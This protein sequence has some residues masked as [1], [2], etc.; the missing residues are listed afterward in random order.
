[1]D[2]LK[3]KITLKNGP[4]FWNFKNLAYGGPIQLEISNSEDLLSIW[5]KSYSISGKKFHFLCD[6]LYIFKIQLILVQKR[7]KNEWKSTEFLQKS[8]IV[9][10]APCTYLIWVKKRK[11]IDKKSGD[12]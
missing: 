12:F 11:E 4:N 5:V 9:Y 10:G 7:G 1:M 6:N 3:T 8:T 2:S